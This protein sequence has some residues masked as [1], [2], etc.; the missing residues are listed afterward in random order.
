M[1]MAL[2]VIGLNERIQNILPKSIEITLR[3]ASVKT[4]TIPP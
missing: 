1:S 3:R 2:D 4:I